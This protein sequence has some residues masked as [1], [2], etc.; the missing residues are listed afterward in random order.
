MAPLPDNPPSSGE[1]PLVSGP[2]GLDVPVADAVVAE[3]GTGGVAAPAPTERRLL[4]DQVAQVMHAYGNGVETRTLPV[5]T[6][7]PT[8]KTFTRAWKGTVGRDVGAV[9]VDGGM[10]VERA[11]HLFPDLFGNALIHSLPYVAQGELKVHDQPDALGVRSSSH[12]CVRLSPEDA[13]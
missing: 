11:W 4:V 2:P 1:A 10:Y 13:Q 5:S 3:A 12:G 8:S 9:S 7:L 6:G